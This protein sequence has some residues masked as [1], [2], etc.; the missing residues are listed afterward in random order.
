MAPAA[1]VPPRAAP[2]PTTE[3]RHGITLTDE[4]AWLKDPNWQAVMRDPALL[5]PDIR[6]YL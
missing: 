1:P 4:F 5:D 2:R 6:A 3:V